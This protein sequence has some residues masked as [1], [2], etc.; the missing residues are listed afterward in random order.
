MR[1][2]TYD[3]F[4]IRVDGVFVVSVDDIE[5][6]SL[7]YDPAGSE[8]LARFIVDACNEKERK[9]ADV[10]IESFTIIDHDLNALIEQLAETNPRTS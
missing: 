9:D 10:T 2:W 6:G 1:T 8:A 4:A 3:R 5:V 7:V